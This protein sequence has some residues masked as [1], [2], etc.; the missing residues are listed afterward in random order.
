MY[1][2]IAHRGASGYEPENTIRAFEKAIELGADMV[3]LDVHLSRD[4]RLIV[5]HNASVDKTTDGSGYIKDLTLQELKTF[6]AGKGEQIPTLQEAIDCVK[7]RCGLYIELKGEYTERPVVEL[8]RENAMQ[9]AVII[10]SFDRNKVRQV[11]E[12]APELVTSVLVDDKDADWVAI[13]K[14]AKADCIHFCWERYRSPHKLLTDE[15]MNKASANGLRVIIWHEERP[16][17]IRE[18][19]KRDIYG[20]CSNLPDLLAAA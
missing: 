10:A 4:G 3:E 7:G 20:I 12:L 13:A 18:I 9:N 5:M 14:D 2:K 15:V 1:L 16:E 6:D 19:I 8:I 17:E 11:K